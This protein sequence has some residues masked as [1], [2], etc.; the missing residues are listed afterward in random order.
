[1]QLAPLSRL[2][3]RLP[4]RR[5]PRFA[6]LFVLTAMA[7]WGEPGARG[8]DSPASTVA[9]LPPEVDEGDPVLAPAPPP[10]PAP[11]EAKAAPP[12]PVARPSQ[13]P[14]QLTA[15][16]QRKLD[17]LS[18]WVKTR[19]AELGFALLDL[20]SGRE[21]LAEGA[22]R[23]LNPASN[24]KLVTAAVA[25]SELGPDFRY[26]VGLYG[27]IEAGV[28]PRLVIRSSGDPTFRFEE[29]KAFAERLTALGLKRVSGDILVDQSA[30]DDQYTPPAFDQQPGEWAAFRA[31]VSAVSL[32]RNS[33][34][35]HVFPTAAGQLARV[36]F[37][38]PGYVSVQGEVRTERGKKRD[39]VGLTMKPRGLLMSAQVSGGL[40]E[41]ET[42]VHITRRIENPEIYAGVVLRR[43]LLNAGVEVQGAVRRG[44]E[45]E[46]GE[47]VGRDSEKLSVLVGQL[48]KASDNF[49]AETLFKTIG[50]VKRGRPGTA[51]N[52]AAVTIEWLKSRQLA[53]E[54]VKVTNG[55]GLY[56][57]NRVS[58]RTLTRLLDAA[59]LDAPI[60][61]P[62]QDQLAVGGLDGTLRSRFYALRSRRSVHAKT[63]TLNK[64]T[65]LSGYVFGPE[66]QTGVAFSIMVTGTTDHA[67][68][69]QRID[70]LVMELSD[71]LWQPRTSA[72]LARR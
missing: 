65:A 46:T 40:P 67:G 33:T 63:G 35:L 10:T 11:P 41:G 49:Y 53:D 47:L 55:S 70:D 3:E 20:G 64:V 28:A 32:D 19:K 5:S 68:A 43:V 7:C 24:Q 12:S 6:A 26:H 2:F 25:L 30:F 36:E 17:A 59:Y 21:L 72:A 34:T 8:A 22:E 27:K 16:A 54:N 71:V 9:T 50:M 52:A 48:G 44:G 57:A 60:S 58:A 37:E 18:S 29:L 62:F 1:M 31:P 14:S 66:Q 42:V 15:R 23:A 69:R 45:D 51:A 13:A 4:Q 61:R 39:H 56:D 38:P